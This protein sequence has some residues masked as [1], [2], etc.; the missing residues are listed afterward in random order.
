MITSHV[1]NPHFDGDKEMECKSD[2]IDDVKGIIAKRPGN[3]R[4]QFRNVPLLNTIMTTLIN[5]YLLLRK[6]D[7]AVRRF[8]AQVT[9]QISFSSHPFLCL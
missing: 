3:L 7:D 4:L 9:V 6:I 8:M 2:Q 1:S 5:Q